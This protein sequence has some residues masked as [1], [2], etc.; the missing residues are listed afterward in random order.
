MLMNGWMLFSAA[1]AAG[2]ITPPNVVLFVID[3][4]GHTDI[5][6]HNIHF[7]NNLKTPNLDALSASGIRLEQ[8]YVQPICTPTRSVLMSGRYQIHTGLQHGVIHPEQPYSLPTSIPLLSN[9]LNSLGYVSH[10]VRPRTFL[11]A[12]PIPL[13]SLIFFFLS[14]SPPNPAQ[15]GKWHLG[16][17][18]NSSCPWN[19]GFGTQNGGSDLGYLGGMEDYWTHYRKPGFDFRDNGIPDH[20]AA[21]TINGDN[22]LYSTRLFRDRAVSIVENH[23]LAYG[24]T[25]KPL[26]LYLPF[27][28]VHSPLESVPFWQK[29]FNLSDFN[30][31]TNRFTLAAMVAEMDH[32][33]GKVVG[34]FQIANM[35]D[36]TVRM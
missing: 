31:D 3:D 22:K 11:I 33:V 21:T 16:F 9:H 6:Y 32:A 27:Q 8:Y 25:G 4:Y 17:Y 26:F 18:T 15:V 2:A 29:Q 5:G 24:A 35:Y 23:S 7:D 28:A 14:L 20:D 36:N 10:K 12:I 1:A 34:A 13:R 19:R 30:G